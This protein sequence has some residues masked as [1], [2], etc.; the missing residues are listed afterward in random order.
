MASNAVPAFPQLQLTH[1]ALFPALTMSNTLATLSNLAKATKQIKFPNGSN[2]LMNHHQNA[3]A[4]LG[5][6]TGADR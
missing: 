2:P 5:H 6:W 1:S 3:Q 4:N